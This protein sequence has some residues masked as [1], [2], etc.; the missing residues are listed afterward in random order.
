MP[1]R[2]HRSPARL[3]PSAGRALAIALLL[4]VALTPATV[5]A[6][7]VTYHVDCAAGSD[8]ASGTSPSSAWRSL[9][10]AN[11]A[12]LRPGDRLLLKRGCTWTGPLVARWAGTSSTPILIGAYGSGDLPK[13]QNAHE[14][15]RITGDHLVIE[16]LWTRSDVPAR[17]SGCENQPMG[18]RVGFR[19]MPESSYVTVRDSRADEQYIGILI[20][21]GA[22]HH[23]VLSNTLRDNRM[24]DADPDS[25]AGAVGISLMGDDN[26]VAYNRISGSDA[27]S[28]QHGRDGAAIEVYGGARNRIHHNTA[29]ENHNFTELGKVGSADNT[30]AYNRITSTLTRANFVVTRGSSDR[31]GPVY[32]TKMFHNTVHLSGSESYAIQCYGGCSSSIFTFRD[33]IVVAQDRVGFADHGFDEG[34]NVYWRP[35]GSPK[36][37]FPISSTSVKAD[38]RFVSLGGGDLHLASGSPAIDRASR[39]AL[40]LGFGKDLDGVTV[41]QGA[42]PDAGAYERTS[43]TSVAPSAYAAD[44]FGRTITDGWGSAGTG[45]RYRL[46]GT[47][48]DFDVP[49]SSGTMVVRPGATRAA[50]LPDAVA[51]DVSLSGRFR[52]D[53]MATGSGTFGY[54]VARQS[55]DARNEY[56]AKLQLLPDGRVL[57]GVNRSLGGTETSV[58]ST[59][60][61]GVTY[62]SGTWLR[63]RVRV[64]GTG[65]TTIR[66]RVWRDGASEPS[67]WQVQVTDS[68][69]ALQG[70]GAVGLRA[71]ASSSA[72][73]ASI[74][75]F[76]DLLVSAP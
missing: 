55:S 52:T 66:V 10:R 76:D 28:R 33:N 74:V 64:T 70:A 34:G 53:R 5:R 68:S 59:A 35:G 75:S 41:P 3:R 37:Y 44:T 15:V 62:T 47:A 60:A 21:D 40:S 57:V 61:T 7:A 63:Y 17:D 46:S 42:A 54:V 51:R 4:L 69:S 26:E 48:A 25:D 72:T 14:N 27:C 16:D 67:T 45:G 39:T 32:R 38:P 12:S 18:W 9:G 11:Q 49:G 1:A 6:A 2:P 36:V 65:P 43:S 24:K 22:H 56:R 8:S 20:E 31:Y 71:Y 29:W 73:R 58:G 19:F 50:S 30:Y 13:I 23:R